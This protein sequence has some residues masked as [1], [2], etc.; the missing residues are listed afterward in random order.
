MIEPRKRDDIYFIAMKAMFWIAF[1]AV[2][3]VA[4]VFAWPILT[5]VLRVLS[6]FIIGLILAY[7]LHPVVRFVQFRLRLGRVAGVF[8]VATMLFTIF[9]LFIAVLI[10]ILYQQITS[11]V[12]DISKYVSSGKLD[13]EI[14]QRIFDD[15]AKEQEFRDRVAEWWSAL[16]DSMREAFKPS[17]LQPVATGSV[18]AVRGTIGVIGSI[19]GW[20]G[21]TAI[22]ITL[23]VIVAFY[24]LVEMARIP[25]IIRRL[26]PGPDRERTWAVMLRA[27]EA[28]GGFLRGQ[29]MACIGVGVLATVFL[30]IIGLKKYAVLIGFTAGAVNFIPYLGPTVGA[31]PAVL[32]AI[33]SQDLPG[34]STNLEL[35]DWGIRLVL[36]GVVIGSFALIQAVDGFVFQPF[37]VGKNAT[38]HPLGVMLALVIGGQIG[39]VGMVLAVPMACIVKVVFVEYFWS[40]RS[41]FLKT[42]SPVSP[43]VASP[44]QPPSEIA[45]A[46]PEAN[47][48]ASSSSD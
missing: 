10:P 26:I 18:G 31:T 5:K 1:F 6:P 41:D 30:F 11:V 35:P 15:P 28:V 43:P 44:P 34:W 27:N 14:L 21:G 48:S 25:P 33:F 47:P 16:R 22:T 20:I 42:S 40:K 19:F 12:E 38:L 2:V 36:I 37:I 24:S 46:T 9:G 32:W 13:D 23:S 17:V 45:A 29:L 4:L 39:I 3:A 8:V 7:V